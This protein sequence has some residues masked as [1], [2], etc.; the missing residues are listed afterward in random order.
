M[1]REILGY[2]T[3]KHGAISLFAWRD[4]AVGAFAYIYP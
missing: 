1:Q 3:S 4:M 2:F